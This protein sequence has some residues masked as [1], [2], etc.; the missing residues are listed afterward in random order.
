MFL[1]YAQS[2][3]I[4]TISFPSIQNIKLS[5]MGKSSIMSDNNNGA[6]QISKMLADLVLNELRAE[7]ANW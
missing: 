1:N 4:S 6:L 2:K 3:N 7:N 5:K